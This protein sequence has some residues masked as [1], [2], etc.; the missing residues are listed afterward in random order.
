[1]ENLDNPRSDIPWIR[2]EDATTSAE[3]N[4][5]QTLAFK[6]NFMVEIIMS[7]GKGYLFQIKERYRIGKKYFRKITDLHE[8]YTV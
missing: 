8:T 1:M 3:E 4:I 2:E 7:K 6:N 5:K